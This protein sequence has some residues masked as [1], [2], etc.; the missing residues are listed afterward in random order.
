MPVVATRSG[1]G[2]SEA[3]E[4]SRRRREFVDQPGQ[5]GKLRASAPEEAK[6]SP[7]RNR[8][9]WRPGRRF[10]PSIRT[11]VLAIV[12]IPS[13]ALLATGATV[14]AVLVSEGL[15]ARTYADRF[16]RFSEPAVQFQSAVQAERSTS[17]RAISGDPQA[18]AGLRATRDR[19][20]FMVGQLAALTA[21]VTE[22]NPDAAGQ[23]IASFGTLGARLPLIRQSVDVHQ[24]SANDVDDF[25]T[26]FT[27]VAVT[28]LEGTARSS[29]DPAAAVEDITATDLFWASDAQS[30][31]AGLAS[32]ALAQ[33]VLSPADRLTQAQLAGTYRNQLNA[34]STRL[35]Q[36]ERAQYEAL[37]N[38]NEWRVATSA[39]DNLAQR[40][41]LNVAMADWQT[42]EDHVSSVLLSLFG[43]HFRYSGTVAKNAAD[44]TLLQSILAGVAVI[45]VAIAAFLVA[46]RLA[47]ALVRR[48]RSLR[49]K[50]LELAD[51]KLPS[52]VQRLHDGEP[53]DVE[54]EMTV[55][56]DGR[57]EIGQ[58]AEAFNTAQRTAIEA[59]ASEAK[60][61]GG[62][63]K[64]FLDI[65]HRSQIVVHRQLEVLDVAEA[66]QGDPEHLEMLFKLDHLATRARRN[67]E[68]LLI[69]GGGQPGRKWRN[70]VA[71]EEIVRS[72]ISET[73]GFERV[74][75]VRLPEVRVLGSVV[76]DLVHL[77]AELVDNAISFSPPDAPVTVRGNLV[78]KGAVIEIED[79]GL[80]IEFD[81]RERL[82]ETL[83]H[84]PAFQELALAGQRNLGLFVIGQLAQRHGISITLLESAYGGVKAIALIPSKVLDEGNH[85]PEA[86]GDGEVPPSPRV[87]RHHQRPSFLPEAVQ[88]PVP[89]MPVEQNEEELRQWPVEEPPAGPDSRPPART[90]IFDSFDSLPPVEAP[91]PRPTARTKAP[92][93][94]RQRQANLAPQLQL[95]NEQQQ[96]KGPTAGSPKRVRSPEDARKSMGSFQRGTSQARDTSG[97]RNR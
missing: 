82:N 22:L 20:D 9:K 28:G 92:L 1:D 32:A 34:V 58:V 29:P 44:T 39:E 81:E 21:D 41:T 71:L 90:S 94:R 17:L 43:N 52:M 8:L 5:G 79:Q 24:A 61:R 38:S 11:R 16:A 66:K 67:A 93:P 36:D 47:N 96:P 89:R 70:P 69:L 86:T 30:R 63:N 57:D 4:A 27:R 15:S 49:T 25:Y 76:A 88:D 46:T 13:A 62:I 91:Q 31:A 53:V 80:G 95:D 6:A 84:P 68:N 12:L 7:W 37:I 75:A 18:A 2:D 14:A 35:T 78:G 54:A 50:T 51:E 55:V 45:L 59:A 42:A 3:P 72:A 77:L 85:P 64:V 74:S 73:E 60:T 65:A 87:G 56:D 48:L 10:R 26:K 40:G 83:R 97:Q 33:G 19:T 23:A